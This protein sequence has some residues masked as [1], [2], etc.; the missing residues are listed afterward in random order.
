[1]GSWQGNWYL[2]N[3]PPNLGY[4]FLKPSCIEDFTLATSMFSKALNDRDS[5][6]FSC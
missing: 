6:T 1:M 2:Q 3:E 4:V 5:S